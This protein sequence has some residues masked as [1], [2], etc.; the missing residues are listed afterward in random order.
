MR[1]ILFIIIMSTVAVLSCNNNSS[2]VHMNWKVAAV[3]PGVNGKNS[4]GYAGPVT[5]T[6]NDKIIIGGGANF[7]DSMPWLGGKKKYYDEVFVYERKDSVLQLSQQQYKL[8]EPI[9]YPAVCSAANG[10]VYAGGEN[11]NGLSAKAWLINVAANDSVQFTSL[12]SLPAAVTNAALTAVDHLVY[13]AGGEITA[14]VS[15]K[16]YCLDLNDTLPGWKELA[17]LPRPTSH[18]LLIAQSG[19]L[20]FIGGRMKTKTGISDL[21]ASVYFYDFSANQWTE[22]KSLPYALSAGTGVPYQSG[23]ILLFGGDKGETFHKT[24]ELIAAIANEKDSVKKKELVQQKINVQSTH[25]G[26]SKQVLLYNTGKDEWIVA[27]TIPFDVPATTTAF[28]SGSFVFIP[29]GEIKAGIRS[30]YI[31]SGKFRDNHQ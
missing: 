24:E 8:P 18:G 29:S 1:L 25:P 15:S 26:F 17:V 22:K 4:L 21:Y 30:P 5:G 19:G 13:L 20:Y 16:F 28:I 31:L 11:N 3:L 9:A 10:I 23:K 12:P 7:P 2:P 14:G 6:V 27:G